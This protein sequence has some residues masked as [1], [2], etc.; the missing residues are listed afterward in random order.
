MALVRI[1]YK[2]LSDVRI[3][4]VKDAERHGVK[5][6]K[7]LVWDSVGQAYGGQLRF[8]NT[9]TGVVVDGLSDEL[10]K[11]LRAEGTFTITEVNK[12]DLS[13]GQEIVSG[14]ALDDTGN[15]V[16]DA[17]TGQKSQKS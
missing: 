10:E 13:D 2:G 6:D 9:A 8:P 15:V 14:Q 7:D 17:T 12:G 4:T 5:L 1:R 11:V 16:K 3:I